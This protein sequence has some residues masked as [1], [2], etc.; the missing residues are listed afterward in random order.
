MALREALGD[1]RNISISMNN[2]G[3]IAAL[4]S[5][6]DEARERFSEVMRLFAE[7]GDT[8]AVAIGQNNLGNALRGLGDHDGARRE[9]AGSLR[10]CRDYDDRWALAFLLEDI[11]LLAAL[12]DDP[13]KALEFVGA[14]EGCRTVIGAARPPSLESELEAK[15]APA[16]M[17]LS[18]G[19]RDACRARGRLYDLSTAIACALEYCSGEASTRR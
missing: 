5:R 14:A 9:Y 18:P 12:C 6:H 4:E 11:G 19:E 7:V 2:L 15:L 17:N 1:R 8:W 13:R 3:M 10:L 16:V